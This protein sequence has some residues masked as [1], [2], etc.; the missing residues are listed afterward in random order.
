MFIFYYYYFI[1]FSDTCKWP[2]VSG[3]F[4]LPW[5]AVMF[6][7]PVLVLPLQGRITQ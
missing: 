7:V 4:V 6:S 5:K 1:Y 3:N 2:A